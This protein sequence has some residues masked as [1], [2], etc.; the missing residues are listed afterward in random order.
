MIPK[1][2]EVKK[3]K[4]LCYDMMWYG[5]LC[6]DIKDKWDVTNKYSPK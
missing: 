3:E 5:I 1:H 4:K 6:Y 2:K